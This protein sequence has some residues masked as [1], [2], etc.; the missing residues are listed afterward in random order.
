[1]PE[2]PTFGWH[3]ES[4]IVSDFNI[5][6][7]CLSLCV[8]VPL[9]LAF[10][11]SQYLFVLGAG[12]DNGTCYLVQWLVIVITVHWVQVVGYMYRATCTMRLRMVVHYCGSNGAVHAGIRTTGL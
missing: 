5:R 4:L 6:F 10:V 8:S 9:S 12:T 2:T 1:M 11:S 3:D 7:V